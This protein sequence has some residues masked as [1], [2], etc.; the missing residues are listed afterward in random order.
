[1]NFSTPLNRFLCSAALS[2]TCFFAIAGL[3]PVQAHDDDYHHHHDN[4][5]ERRAYLGHPRSHYVL[6]YGVGYAGRGYYY[7]PPKASW[8]YEGPSVVYYRS[9]EAAPRGIGFGAAQR[10]SS[11]CRRRAAEG[12]MASGW[13]SASRPASMSPTSR[14]GWL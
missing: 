5:R 13:S 6:S 2:L 8:Y 3:S 1:M 11:V 12:G 9:R 10:A 14:F 7:G 4:P